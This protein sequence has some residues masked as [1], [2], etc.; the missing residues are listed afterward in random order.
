MCRLL[1]SVVTWTGVWPWACV[2]FPHDSQTTAT[3]RVQT[4]IR[5]NRT[6]HLRFHF[7]VMP[8]SSP[9]SLLF[10]DTPNG[11]LRPIALGLGYYFPD[12]YCAGT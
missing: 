2:F 5:P 9:Y 3:A 10:V 11:A 4:E 1:Q 6:T 7:V 8:L 12:N